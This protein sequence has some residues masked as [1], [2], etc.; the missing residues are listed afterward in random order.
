[1]EKRKDPK[2]D[3]KDDGCQRLSRECTTGRNSPKYDKDKHSKTKYDK[4]STKD[5]I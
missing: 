4:C 5:K 2:V 3:I 1:M